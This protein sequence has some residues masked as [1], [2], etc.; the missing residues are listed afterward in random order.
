[1]K[2]PNCGTEVTG[3]FCANC[4][5]DLRMYSQPESQEVE[6]AVSE[7]NDDTYY[8]EPVIVIPAMASKPAKKKTS[9]LSVAAFICSFAGGLG[10]ILAI[11]D[12]IKGRN[13]GKKHG[14]SIAAI[15]I[16]TIL[17]ITFFPSDSKDGSNVSSQ[18]DEASVEVVRISEETLDEA[19]ETPEAADTEDTAEPVPN[20]SKEEF[21]A[22]CDV[23]PYKELARNPEKYI[24]QNYLL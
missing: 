10:I 3:D 23:M 5:A 11:I 1:M 6:Q 7:Q 16:G 9:G 19:A 21:M 15:V 18:T 13:D 14:L 17:I 4:G 2:C 22:S 20:V 24:G 12:L 8:E